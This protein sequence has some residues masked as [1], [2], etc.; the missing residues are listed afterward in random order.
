MH[1]VDENN[2]ADRSGN[3]ASAGTMQLNGSQMLTSYNNTSH[4][5]LRYGL[6]YFP[7]RQEPK[8][9]NGAEAT[10]MQIHLRRTVSITPDLR[11]YC[12]SYPST[13]YSNALSFWRCSAQP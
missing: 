7:D 4:V 11:S 8:L 10:T 6:P 12:G 13:K 3:C 5:F 9:H 2:E 1:E